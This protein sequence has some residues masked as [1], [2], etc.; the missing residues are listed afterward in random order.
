MR[1]RAARG[2]Q[3]ACRGPGRPLTRGATSAP[4]SATWRPGGTGIC[5]V[6]TPR[7]AGHGL[8][9]RWCTTRAVRSATAPMRA[10]TR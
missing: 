10:P 1:A 5:M 2:L 7:R 4:T 6:W 8:R 9:V 3:K